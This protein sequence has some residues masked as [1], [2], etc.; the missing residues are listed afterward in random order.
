MKTLLFGALGLAML[1]IAP[2]SAY[3]AVIVGTNFTDRVITGTN[4]PT[5][6]VGDYTLNGVASPGAWTVVDA[7]ENLMISTTDNDN[8][9]VVDDNAPMWSVTISLEVGAS[10]ISLSDVTIDYESFDNGENSKIA[11]GFA[12]YHYGNVILRNGITILI[13]QELG[14][15]GTLGGANNNA[16]VWTGVYTGFSGTTLSANQTYT[17]EIVSRG[18]GGNNVGLDSFTISGTVVP[19]PSTTAFFGLGGIALILRRGKKASYKK[20]RQA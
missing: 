7:P 14:N 1:F 2:S 9:F 8:K 6:L 19:E 12:P 4:S 5:A 16:P 15:D 17:L 18:E 11:S 13:Q 20:T 10:N 3:G